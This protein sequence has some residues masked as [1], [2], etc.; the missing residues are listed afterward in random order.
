MTNEELKRITNLKI[1]NKMENLSKDD[2]ARLQYDLQ[3]QF[4]E[5]GNVQI[6]HLNNISSRLKSYFGNSYSKNLDNITQLEI[7]LSYFLEA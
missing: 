7:K 5:T 3:K 1:E 4:H 2:P 6:P